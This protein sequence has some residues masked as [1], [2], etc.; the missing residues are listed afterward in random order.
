MTGGRATRLR[1]LLFAK[2]ERTEV[3]LIRSALAS[4]LGFWGDFATLAVLTEIVD[5]YYLV[6]A[7]IAFVVGICIT[8][9]LSVAWIFKHRRIKSKI[10]EFGVFCLIAVLG[11][12]VML[13]AMW[14]FT[15]FLHLHYLISKIVASVLVFA[16]NFTLRKFLLFHPRQRNSP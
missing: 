5:I 14:F 7:I 1:A 4:H 9:C 8:Y 2:T 13:G 6:S 12:G 10:A 3:Q 15:E 16:L 11:A